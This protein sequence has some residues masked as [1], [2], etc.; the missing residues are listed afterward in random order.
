MA[1]MRY[2]ISPSLRN[3]LNYSGTRILF[4]LVPKTMYINK[5]SH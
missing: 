2:E 1:Y 4:T 5:N 3:F